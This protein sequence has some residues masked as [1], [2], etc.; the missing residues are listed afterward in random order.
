MTRCTGDD[1]RLF[2]WLLG[3]PESD[4]LAYLQTLK[5]HDAWLDF[6]IKD[7][8]RYSLAEWQ[9]EHT[10]LFV[11]GY[12]RTPCPPFASAYLDGQMAGPA[13]AD[14]ARFYAQ[15]GLC[16]SSAPADYLGNLLMF[17]ADQ[18]AQGIPN[19]N[20]WHAVTVDYMNSWIPRFCDDLGTAAEM[21]LYR[22]LA[23]ALA[24]CFPLWSS[25]HV[26]PTP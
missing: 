17:A 14:L 3:T 11:T 5:F 25:S 21:S 7:L 9:A 13:R 8:D 23:Q 26:T 10:R 1:W 15:C 16:A 22:G 6:A 12:P 2:G 19:P 18:L 20:V 4:S 24:E